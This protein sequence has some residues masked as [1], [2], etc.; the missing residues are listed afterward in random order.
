MISG[1]GSLLLSY[2]AAFNAI[3]VLFC[4]FGNKYL[5]GRTPISLL[6]G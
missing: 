1:I 3:V 2:L 6:S 4:L 5:P